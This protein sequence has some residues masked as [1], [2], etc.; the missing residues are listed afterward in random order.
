MG[1]R[2]RFE[3]VTFFCG[4]RRLFDGLDF[5]VG[6]GEAVVVTGRSGDGKSAL[7]EMAAG[8][9]S[10]AS[11]R[12]LWDGHDVA[13]MSSDEISAKRNRIG[14]VFQHNAL[15]SNFTVLENVALPLRYHFGLPDAEIRQRVGQMLQRQ[16]LAQLASRR[17]EELAEGEARMVA[18]ARALILEPDLL[19]LD[20]PDSGIDQVFAGLALRAIHMQRERAGVAILITSH[21]MHNIRQ[22]QCP[23]AVI[24]NGRLSFLKHFGDAQ[25]HTLDETT[26]LHEAT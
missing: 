25:A 5:S 12:V 8:L 20:E 4:N 14:F 13:H 17:P 19:L 1:D 18:L 10:P 11:G 2:L 7:L 26:F 16:G 6:R 21:I 23:V 24:A 3:N 9:I 15:I 22:M